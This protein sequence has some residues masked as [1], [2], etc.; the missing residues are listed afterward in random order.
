MYRRG[1]KR[2]YVEYCSSCHV[3]ERE[4]E[5]DTACWV[6]LLFA[7]VVVVGQYPKEASQSSDLTG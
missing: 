6:A 7:V 1:W 4:I 2:R 5:T 3:V